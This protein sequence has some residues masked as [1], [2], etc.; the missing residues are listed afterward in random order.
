MPRKYLFFI[1]AIIFSITQTSIFSMHADTEPAKKSDEK[2]TEKIDGKNVVS[3]FVEAAG[4]GKLE[5]VESLWEQYAEQI[6]TYEGVS[7]NGLNRAFSIAV[8]SDHLEVVHW[9]LVNCREEIGDGLL[10]ELSENEKQVGQDMRT[11]L[12]L[13]IKIE[14]QCVIL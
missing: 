8:C 7:L 9:F 14:E 6:R 3:Q 2:Q 13:F 4:S 5:V 1:L 10:Y 12:Q 11:Q